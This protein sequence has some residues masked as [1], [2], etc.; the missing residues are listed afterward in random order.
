[1]S[2]RSRFRH[3]RDLGGPHTRDLRDEQGRRRRRVLQNNCGSTH[4]PI[5]SSGRRAQA[6]EWRSFCQLPFDD[7]GIRR[8]S[9]RCDSL[10]H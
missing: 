2:T 8:F 10:R 7:S 6:P 5:P 3:Y 9:C 1:M 4:S